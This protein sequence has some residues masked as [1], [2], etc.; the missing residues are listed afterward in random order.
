MSGNREGGFKAA[1]TSKAKYGETFYQRIG[2]KGGARKSKKGGFAANPELARRAGAKGGRISKRGKDSVSKA[3]IEPIADKIIEEYKNGDPL[4]AIAKRHNLSYGVLC[5]WARNNILTL[6]RL[7]VGN[8]IS[9][10][11]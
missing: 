10:C 9:P 11:E 3:T 8:E 5:R 1:A 6:R 7:N 4:T 2:R